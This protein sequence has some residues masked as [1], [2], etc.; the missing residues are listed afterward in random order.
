MRQFF[1]KYWALLV[2]CLILLL[3]TAN[4]ICCIISPKVGIWCT[5]F[6]GFAEIY[7]LLW[8]IDLCCFMFWKDINL[9]TYLS[10][11]FWLMCFIPL[12]LL[13]TSIFLILTII[14]PII[15][16]VYYIKD[17]NIDNT[18]DI[19]DYIDFCSFICSTLKPE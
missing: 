18:P 10:R 3:Q 4:L 5:L 8:I 14:Y 16:A 19:E 7:I 12:V 13:L 1:N 2:G 9:H 15:A 17:G 11:F 6:A